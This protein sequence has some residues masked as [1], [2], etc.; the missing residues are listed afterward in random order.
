MSG[1]AGLVTVTADEALTAEG[2]DRALRAVLEKEIS[3]FPARSWYP[4]SLGHPCDRFLVWSWT[5]WQDKA[6]H[7]AVLQSIFDEGREHQPLIYKRLEQM[8]FEVIRE[9]DRPTQYKLAGGA[10]ISGRPDGRLA[11]F[12]GQRYKPTP[13]LEAKTMSSFQWDKVHTVEDLRTSAQPWTRAYYAQG[14]LY[15]FLE[16]TPVGLFVIKNKTTGMLKC[17]PYELDMAFAESVLTRIER[18]LAPMVAQGVDPDPIPFDPTICGQCA[19]QGQCYPPRDFGPGTQILED[20]VLIEQL[21]A[22]ENLKAASDEYQALDKAV[23]AQLKRN[24]IKVAI[25]GPFQ[26]ELTERGVKEYTV[27]A[28][29]DLVVKITRNA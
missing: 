16:N 28:R 14:H 1:Q 8:G 25:A 23:K 15:C 29:T 4:S 27:P 10:V 19:F 7:D 21:E 12:K 22:R 24:G 20:P 11:A 26:I 3:V 9:S 17:L 13:I 18:R 5:R 2:F 6:R